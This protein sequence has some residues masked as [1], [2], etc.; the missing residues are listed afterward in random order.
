MGLV[1]EEWR[2]AETKMQDNKY[3]ATSVVYLLF[4]AVFFV[5]SQTLNPESI[6]AIPVA[7]SAVLFAVIDY[8]LQDEPDKFIRGAVVSYAVVTVYSLAHL[9]L[10]LYS[11]DIRQGLFFLTVAGLTQLF[12]YW[13]NLDKK[14]MEKTG[15]KNEE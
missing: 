4:I 11:I 6:P 5:Y 13:I 3:I 9:A 10:G 14:L 12:A 2:N 15:R 8:L 1:K 7:I